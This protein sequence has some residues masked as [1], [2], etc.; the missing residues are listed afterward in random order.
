MKIAVP[1][2]NNDRINDH[3]GSSESY[4]VFTI[5]EEKEITDIR[6]VPSAAGCGCKSDIA[7]TL[8]T[9]G[10][11]VLLAGG[12]GGGAVN[13][14]TSSG[15]SV[16]RGCS[17]DAREAVRLYLEG[18][19]EDTGSNCHKHSTSAVHIHQHHHHTHGHSC[20]HS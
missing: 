17:G 12:I 2:A 19:I 11:T 7:S 18:K 14:F 6:T 15:I 16:V 3:F 5:S 1:L 20:G 13:K 4:G 9:D 10:V 8:A